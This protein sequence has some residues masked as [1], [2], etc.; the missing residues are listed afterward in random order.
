[1]VTGSSSDLQTAGH[2]RRSWMARDPGYSRENIAA[3]RQSWRQRKPRGVGTR[4]LGREAAPNIYWRGHTG[5]VAKSGR[6]PAP[7]PRAYRGERW[8]GQAPCYALRRT[9]S[10][11]R[12]Q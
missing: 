2:G 12:R 9:V 11:V 8:T 7:T 6:I 5:S 3:P 1:V 4:R 10:P